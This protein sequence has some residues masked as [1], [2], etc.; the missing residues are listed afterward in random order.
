M[1]KDTSGKDKTSKDKLKIDPKKV[2]VLSD[3]DLDSVA[4]GLRPA[5]GRL[6]AKTDAGDSAC[7]T[8]ATNTKC[9]GATC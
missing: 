9:S 3:A 2:G 8:D 7:N 5:G 1:G 4:G 6:G